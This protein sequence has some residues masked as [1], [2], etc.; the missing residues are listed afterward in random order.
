MLS[1]IYKIFWINYK[2]YELLLNHIES[3]ELIPNQNKYVNHEYSTQLIAK[4]PKRLLKTIN[5]TK[6]IT[7][8]IEKNAANWA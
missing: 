4:Q 5:F 7:L 8:K 3:D 1:Y 6:Y 2:E